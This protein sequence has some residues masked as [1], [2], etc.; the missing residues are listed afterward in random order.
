[1][2]FQFMSESSNARPMGRFPRREGF[3]ESKLK[4][5]P[6]SMWEWALNMESPTQWAL[7]SQF[8][9]RLLKT[10]TYIP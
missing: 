10:N 9:F 1:M 8:S 6:R 3:P 7:F 5:R 2:M 4:P